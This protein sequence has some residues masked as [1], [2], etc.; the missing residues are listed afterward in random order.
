[1]PSLAEYL[2]PYLGG[3]GPASADVPT[4]ESPVTPGQVLAATGGVLSPLGQSWLARAGGQTAKDVAAYQSGGVPA[5]MADTGE[6]PDLAGGFAG[7]G[8]LGGKLGAQRLAA[9]GEPKYLNAWTKAETMQTAG[10]TPAEILQATTEMGAPISTGKE[11][12]FRYEMPDIGTHFTPEG[13]AAIARG[14][15]LPFSEAYRHPELFTAYPEVG[16][17]KIRSPDR[18]GEA[19]SAAA[20]LRLPTDRY[21]STLTR[22]RELRAVLTGLRSRRSRHSTRCDRPACTSLCTPYNQ[23]KSFPPAAVWTR[24]RS[25]RR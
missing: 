7:A 24:P 25:C 3:Y 11:G 14:G 6:T 20:A 9:A 2:A 23:W 16:N 22:R 1:M 17:L 19:S 13:E 21:S 10:H 15:T 8:I 18:R 5:L 12:G 4:G